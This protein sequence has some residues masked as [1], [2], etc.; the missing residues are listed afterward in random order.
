MTRKKQLILSLIFISLNTMFMSMSAMNIVN[1]MWPYD[2][3]IRPTFNNLRWWQLAF[4]A[5]GGFHNAKGYNDEGGVANPLRIWNCEQN[6][7]AMLE[8][9]PESSAIGQLRSALL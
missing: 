6:A 5:E 4:Y 2:T 8:G 9:F 1:T 3:L 7:L